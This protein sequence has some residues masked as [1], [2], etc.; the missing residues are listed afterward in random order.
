MHSFVRNLIT[1]W[2]RL[3]IPFR[4]AAIV[5]AVS[6]GADS[7]SLLTAIDDLRNR[8]KFDLRI[9]AAHFDHKLRPDSYTDCDFVADF[10]RSHHFEFAHSEW[11][12]EAG[13]N[14]EQS[15]RDARYRFLRDTADSVGAGYVLTAHTMSD[16]AET[17]LM[18]LIRGAGPDGLSGMKPRRI[19]AVATPHDEDEPF[20]PFAEPQ[21][22]VVRPLLRWAKRRDT[23]NFCLEHK[24]EYCR[25]PMNE[26]LNF[27]RIWIR[28]V[29]IPM[30]EE[31]NPKLVESLC[32][33]AEL[34][35][36]E[37]R[38]MAVPEASYTGTNLDVAHLRTL[39][40]A[41]VF[42]IL[43]DWIKLNRGSLRGISTKHTEAIYSLIHSQK[44][45]RVAELPGGEAIK[46][47]GRLSWNI[48]RP[49]NS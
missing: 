22:V 40:K 8:K 33:T 7:M 16:Q 28:K 2:R 6:G 26:D 20:L 27:R 31:A 35:R 23:E 46:H 14:L 43:R 15:A 21:I 48:R 37:A 4:E 30:M 32:R 9:V 36:G 18:N 25:D 34:M 13:G 42:P 11:K 39:E 29:L 5:V 49:E 38:P 47:D 45:G 12:R 44:S 3:E 41:E 1:E 10:A 19:L 24:I 17:F